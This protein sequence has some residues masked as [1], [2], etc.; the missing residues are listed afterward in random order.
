MAYII[1]KGW[2][3]LYRSTVTLFNLH[4]NLTHHLIMPWR[5]L[6][7]Q[8]DN[9]LS[10][11]WMCI[12]GIPED[13][14]CVMFAGWR[15]FKRWSNDSDSVWLSLQTCSTDWQLHYLVVGVNL[16]FNKVCKFF[17]EIKKIIV[18]LWRSQLSIKCRIFFRHFNLSIAS[19]SYIPG[20][21]LTGRE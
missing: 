18:T 16:F 9:R 7:L 20:L 19:N 14:C 21:I 11:V 3:S 10:K 17:L 5:C 2:R 8:G 13:L 15:N 6:Y 4:F 1:L 12:L